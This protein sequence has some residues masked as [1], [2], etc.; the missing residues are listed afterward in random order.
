MNL[1]KF[2]RR[3]YTAGPTPIERIPRFSEALGGPQVY[4]KR[5]DLLGLTGGGNKTRKLEFLVA[6][7]LA[8]GCDTL[9]T[10]GGIQSNHCRLTLAAAVKEG[11]NCWLVLSEPS[12]GA[13]R[14]D[15]NG[16]IFLYHLLGA[17]KIKIVPDGVD[18]PTELR[19]AEAE[20]VAAGHRPYVIPMG[21]SNAIGALGYAAC[22]AEIMGQCFDQS[23]SVDRIVV[24]GGSAG[25]L[26][27][28]LLGLELLHFDVPVTAISVVNPNEELLADAKRIAADTAAYLGVDAKVRPDA[29]TCY[30]AYIG[31]GY[32]QPTKE[33]VAAVKLLAR[34]EGIL[35]DPTYTGKAMAGLIDLARQ[36]VIRPEENV[37][38]LHTGGSPSLYAATHLFAE[39]PAGGHEE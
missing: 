28:T 24:A 3:R 15:A 4:I 18:W 20:A 12:S 13:Y 38:F 2:P 5:D 30:D 33:M 7:A 14:A 16:N 32:G 39:S 6:D 31:P 9:I 10:C 25:T 37:L 35:L 11:L 29:V 8:Q 23:L 17:G 1:A 21:G 27:G 19:V 36:G 34:S 22:A 26:A